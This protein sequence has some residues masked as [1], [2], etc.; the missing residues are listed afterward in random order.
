MR[1]LIKN[2]T[3]VTQNSQR[4]I[5][6]GD[7]LLEDDRIIAIGPCTEAA[8]KV[9]D[10]KGDI[11]L[12]GLINTHTHVSMTSLK[13]L[14][15]DVTFPNFLDKVFHLDDLRKPRDL[16][17]GA[18]QGCIE[19][20]R[21]GTTTFLDLYYSE[22]V[23]AKAVERSGIRGVLGWAVL[24]QEFT[25]QKGDPLDNCKHFY[26]EFKSHERIYPA[27]GLQGVY[28]C[29]TET[30]M[31]AKEFAFEED[32]T[33][34]F[35]LSE[36]RKEVSDCKK[37]EGLRPADYLANIGFFNDH[38]VAAHSAW[39]TMNE[40]RA[41]AQAG[42]KVSSCPV[43]NM[44]LATGG[45]APIP[46]MIANGMTV[47]LGTDGSTTNNSLD[48]FGEMK[49]VSLLQK[50][51]R[52]DPTV[53]P[54]QQ[55]LDFTTINAAKALRMEQEIGSLEVGK[56]AD[57]IILDGKAPNL[58]P[59]F[60]ETLVSNIVYSSY[61]LNVKTVLCDGKVVMEDKEIK[62]MDEEKELAEANAAAQEL[63]ESI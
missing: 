51:A 26:N 36:T 62:S 8:D 3:V 56:K 29:S 17:A 2:G 43:S 34:T 10:A 57:L 46:E 58:R 32:L 37:K 14:V 54:A 47:S 41:M 13:G 59:F 9:I 23:I 19:M 1:T 60:P 25:T 44:K 38:C 55:V 63:Y 11:I 30:F 53:L 40:V 52:W 4:E 18:A 42:V 6:N 22:D 5:V 24:D 31:Q 35:H 15:D 49:F 7:V 33:L 45:V 16:E 39:L 20:I 21:S 61:G 50:S 28:V 27:I 12:P 48:L